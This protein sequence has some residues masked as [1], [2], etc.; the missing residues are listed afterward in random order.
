MIDN[1]V[2]SYTEIKKNLTGIVYNLISHCYY[3]RYIEDAWFEEY[4]QRKKTFGVSFTIRE[5][6]SNVCYEL[7]FLPENNQTAN[8]KLVKHKLGKNG[9]AEESKLIMREDLWVLL[10]AEDRETNI[11]PCFVPKWNR[12]H[13]EYILSKQQKRKEKRQAGYQGLIDTLQETV[14]DAYKEL[15]EI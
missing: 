8:V 12:E 9:V 3:K 5:V 6:N 14:L 13:Y 10:P 11:Y 15:G 7:T 2:S 4:D 1:K